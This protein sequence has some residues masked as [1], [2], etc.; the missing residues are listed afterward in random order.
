MKSRFLLN[1][2]G[3]YRFLNL[4]GGV[5]VG[6]APK[7][8]HH[9]MP[10]KD[11]FA[12][13]HPLPRFLSEHADE[14]DRLRVVE[15]RNRTGISS[16]FV[17]T[18]RALIGMATAIGILTVEDPVALFTTSLL[19]ISALLPAIGQSTA[20]IS[21]LPTLRT[22]RRPQVTRRR[23][24]KLQRLLNPPIRVRP[25][26]IRHRP[27]ICSSDSKHG[28]LP[29]KNGQRSS[30]HHPFKMP[31]NRLCKMPDQISRS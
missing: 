2:A 1:R 14:P 6:R 12:P 3:D 25:K 15:A 22:C 24:A 28:R 31:Q 20:A 17:L 23:A 8:R 16:R 9:A 19:E 21:P 5:L 30:P 7:S 18:T 27:K 29:K 10:T 4:D 13:G 11:G 26:S